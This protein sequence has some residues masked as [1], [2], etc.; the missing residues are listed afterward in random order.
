M[1]VGNDTY[2]FIKNL[3]GDLTK[4]IDEEGT[5]WAS[6]IYDPKTSRF[7]NAD[8]PEYTDTGSGSPLSTNMFAYCE[9]DPV[10]GYDPSGY[11]DKEDHKKMTKEAG[12]SMVYSVFGKNHMEK[13]TYKGD[14]YE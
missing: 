4:I 7:I 6:Y 3:Q 1:S 9:N 10:S 5:V 12:F 11:W 14:Q 8:A 13:L 2:Y